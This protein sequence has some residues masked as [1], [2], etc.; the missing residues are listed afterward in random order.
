MTQPCYVDFAWTKPAPAA[1]KASGYVGVI[2]YVSHDPAKNLTET[3]AQGYYAQGLDVLLVWEST[4]TDP[5]NGAPAGAADAAAA[6]AQAT[7]Y[8][9]DPAHPIFYATDFGPTQAQ[10]SAVLAYYEGVAGA[11]RAHG[12]GPYG[13]DAVVETVHSA[14]IGAGA[15]WQTVAWSA[16]VISPIANLFQRVTPT[17]PPIPGG[18]YDEDVL[19]IP[20]TG[21]KPTPST[22]GKNM[23]ADDQGSK[24]G[25]WAL[26]P[27]GG[28]FTADG[29]PFLGSLAGNRF[30][31]QAVG[32]L[33]GI[34]AWWDG[35]AWGYKISV[36]SGPGQYAY[37]R[38]PRNGSLTG[39][40]VAVPSEHPAA[41]S[42]ASNTT[43]WAADAGTQEAK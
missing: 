31:W 21:A 26:G 18:G 15:F 25:S 22:G 16:G 20:I 7:W 39:V 34:C 37:Y 19:L 3:Q 5:A 35:T 41:V 1:V 28:I 33:D 23:L 40:G 4:G 14:R 6:E 36:R 12:F 32:Q 43:A 10:M 11:H 8:P 29:S 2:G 27:D 38:F 42:A 30:N 17:K 24:S 9:T 13:D